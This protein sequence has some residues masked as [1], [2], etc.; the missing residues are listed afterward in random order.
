MVAKT[1]NYTVFN[2]DE[3]SW[4]I[5]DPITKVL[6]VG[7]YKSISSDASLMSNHLGVTR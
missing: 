4:P 7:R 2:V 5:S 1:L 6:N 3:M